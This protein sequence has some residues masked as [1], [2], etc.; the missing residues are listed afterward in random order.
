[1]VLQYWKRSFK[2]WPYRESSV[3]CHRIEIICC[4]VSQNRNDLLYCVTD[5]NNTLL[6]CR[7]TTVKFPEALL[8][9]VVEAGQLA[10][11]LVAPWYGIPQG[12]PVIA[13]LGDLQCS[14][15]SRLQ[16]HDDAGKSYPIRTLKNRQYLNLQFKLLQVLLQSTLILN[17]KFKAKNINT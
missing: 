8:P 15:L 3:L 17:L 6:C 5:D 13:A 12:T 10:G 11:T 1:M 16:R 2:R 7:L 14:I 4:I 9:E